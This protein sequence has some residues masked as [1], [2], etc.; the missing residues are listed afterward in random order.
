MSKTIMPKQCLN[1]NYT[2]I[3]Y[4]GVFTVADSRLYINKY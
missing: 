2:P 4:D 3:E 1:K